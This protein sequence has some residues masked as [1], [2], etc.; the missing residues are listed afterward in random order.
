[1]TLGDLNPLEKLFLALA[2][3]TR[4]RL[5][6]LMANG[7]VSVGYLADHLNESQPKISRHLAY[8]RAAGLASTRR[9]GKW[10]YYGIEKQTDDRAE[11]V[12]SCLLSDLAGTGSRPSSTLTHT[13]SFL[14]ET[15]D[16]IEIDHVYDHPRDELD[17]H[18]L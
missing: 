11:A 10:I 6:A 9:D 13:R 18:L 2:D 8:L 14:V 7:E 15:A 12:L 5:L 17:I 4:L 3:K 16:P 1:M